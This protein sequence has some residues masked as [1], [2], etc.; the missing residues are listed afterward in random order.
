[1]YIGKEVCQGCSKSGEESRRDSKNSLCN[2]CKKVLALGR[3]AAKEDAL[4]Y[5][6][7][8][9]WFNGYPHLERGEFSLD[10]LANNLFKILNNDNAIVT[11]GDVRTPRAQPHGSTFYKLP[12][13]LAPALLTFFSHLSE[14]IKSI[15]LIKEEAEREARR[16][17]SVEKN[18]IFNE[19]V[20][21]GR[22]LLFSLNNG[23][24]TME[25][26]SKKINKF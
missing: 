2:L 25:D 9:D 8:V 18:R 11:Q 23:S 3:T 24:I 14:D 4:E 15:K 17:V 7:I 20:E 21:K 12:T 5:S 13:D 10:A 1:M 16:A 6:R 19:G 26:F 22:E